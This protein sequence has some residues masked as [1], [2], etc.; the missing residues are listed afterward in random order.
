MDNKQKKLLR[1][2]MNENKATG[3]FSLA[4]VATVMQKL[5]KTIL[6]PTDSI[7]EI[8]EKQSTMAFGDES[9]E[10]QISNFKIENLENLL[11][12]K[13]FDP[14][15]IRGEVI[16]GTEEEIK[17]ALLGDEVIQNPDA[18]EKLSKQANEKEQ[19]IIARFL[20]PTSAPKSDAAGKTPEQ[21]EK[22]VED[23]MRAQNLS[24]EEA[25]QRLISLSAKT[26]DPIPQDYFDKTGQASQEDL[27]QIR[28]LFLKY[29]PLNQ[30]IPVS[31]F[32]SS[33]I[34]AAFV[35]KR[36]GVT[37]VFQRS[38]V[39]QYVKK[40]AIVY[41]W[42]KK[43]R[44]IAITVQEISKNLPQNQ[45][46]PS[47]KII[48]TISSILGEA[49]RKTNYIELEENEDLDIQDA[50]DA[51]DEDEIINNWVKEQ[52]KI[53]NNPFAGIDE[54]LNSMYGEERIK[55]ILE[56]ARLI[57]NK[58]PTLEQY[59]ATVK[60]V[61]ATTK[62]V[63]DAPEVP[64]KDKKI[65]KVKNTVE[66]Y[67]NK[68]QNKKLN[69]R[70]EDTRNR[71]LEMLIDSLRPKSPDVPFEDDLADDLDQFNFNDEEQ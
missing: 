23:I 30:E 37:Q 48:K 32:P 54:L 43:I 14:P 8:L 62:T 61:Q 38:D 46:D 28:K 57:F 58:I 17:K 9:S 45:Q 44:D 5:R 60:K 42:L 49:I 29:D 59:I 70:L 40:T 35:K 68:I 16:T 52:G 24:R 41:W 15:R 1:K 47:V 12:L 64:T 11:N 63:G 21:I 50:S 56:N 39:E 22:S 36:F 67:K 27:E 6:N 19:G 20:N 33:K 13:N 7:Y 18:V 26:E 31:I 71:V 25:Q 34:E 66:F 10:V 3:T 65:Q 51:S 53:G 69:P 2:I 4:F 55:K